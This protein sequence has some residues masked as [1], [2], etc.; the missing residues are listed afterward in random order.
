VIPD[1]EAAVRRLLSNLPGA[2]PDAVRAMRVRA[3]CGVELE[4]RIPRGATYL[5]PAIV[6]GF[7]VVYLAGVIA[8][9]LRFEGIL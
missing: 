8:L 3:R 7:C 5:E 2:K 1:D 6:G 4:R 9:A